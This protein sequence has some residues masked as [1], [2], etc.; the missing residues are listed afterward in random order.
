MDEVQVWTSHAG[1]RMPGAGPEHRET[2]MLRCERPSHHYMLW[3]G[4]DHG[5]PA[6]YS[7]RVAPAPDDVGTHSE[8]GHG[9]RDGTP[10]RNG[11]GTIRRTIPQ[12]RVTPSFVTV[13]SPTG[14]SPEPADRVPPGTRDAVMPAR[15]PPSG[16][17][18]ARGG[19]ARAGTEENG[20]NGP[21]S[22][23]CPGHG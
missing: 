11:A 13:R 9:P 5:P 7:S 10:A 2:H 14:R 17:P 12:L 3:F 1:M 19:P 23:G 6:T 16:P 21:D 22:R 18:A 15:T 20:R 8:R 4:L